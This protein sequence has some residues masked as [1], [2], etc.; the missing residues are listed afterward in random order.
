M[1]VRAIL[2]V[3]CVFFCK[4]VHAYSR[5]PSG[6]TVESPVTFTFT[7][8]ELINCSSSNWK[9]Q[10]VDFSTTTG[11]E[12]LLESSTG[13]SVEMACG[14][15]AYELNSGLVRAIS[16]P[17]TN[18]DVRTSCTTDPVGTV[19]SQ[20][21]S[22]L[23]IGADSFTMTSSTSEEPAVDEDEIDVEA[24][25]R[26]IQIFLLAGIFTILLWRR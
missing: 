13:T 25:E 5:S 8:A 18:V 11:K 7:A 2:C 1:D 23:A 17:T 9:A 16:C 26:V 14:D 21:S 15:Q 20:Y 19:S 12:W 4:P 24:V 3:Y 6:S 22:A 10:W